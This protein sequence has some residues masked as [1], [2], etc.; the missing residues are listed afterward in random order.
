MLYSFCTVCNF[1]SI[2]LSH[3]QSIQVFNFRFDWL[4][5]HEWN[6]MGNFQL[7]FVFG[8]TVPFNVQR[9][10]HV[11]CEAVGW[12]QIQGAGRWQLHCI[13]TF[14]LHAVR[15]P[16][17][18]YYFVFGISHLAFRA[19]S[20]ALDADGFISH[21]QWLRTRS[22][23][24]LLE[25]Y[26]K[27]ERHLWS[28]FGNRISAACSPYACLICKTQ[29]CIQIMYTLINTPRSRGKRESEREWGG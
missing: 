27:R 4:N 6:L 15:F 19:V 22:T 7:R 26:A 13:I 28:G 18:Y 17:C 21:W 1:D 20:N 16:H 2:C 24:S 12:P 8:P 3:L 5:R 23:W 25:R 29:S 9:Q 10:I 11:A 14:L